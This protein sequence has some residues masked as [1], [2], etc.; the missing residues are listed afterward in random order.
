[1]KISTEVYTSKVEECKLF[2]SNLLDFAVKDENE[3]FVV[4]QHKTKP[5]YELMFCVPNSP[6]VNKVY[7]KEFKGSGVL[8]QIE[9]DDVYNMYYKIKESGTPLVLDLVSEPFN[10]THFTIKDPSG[11]LI[12]VVQFDKN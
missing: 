4:L 7:H 10:G 9:T 2:Y 12:D 11:V 1:M 3:G 6:F 5:M 8:I